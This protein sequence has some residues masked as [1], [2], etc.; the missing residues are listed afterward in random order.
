MRW[1]PQILLSEDV[2]I[3]FPEGQRTGFFF[4]TLGV[5]G[6]VF[7][8]ANDKKERQLVSELPNRQ[9]MVFTKKITSLSK[10]ETWGPRVDLSSKILLNNKKSFRS[11]DFFHRQKSIQRPVVEKPIAPKPLQGGKACDTLVQVLGGEKVFL[12]LHSVLTILPPPGLKDSAINHELQN[13]D[14]HNLRGLT[15]EKWRAFL[16]HHYALML[17]LGLQDYP[18]AGCRVPHPQQNERFDSRYRLD[19]QPFKVS[20]KTLGFSLFLL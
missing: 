14:C 19:Q 1:I 15:H 11:F 13:A 5:I 8:S 10:N 17:V 9:V 6:E 4:R 16:L 12:K 3:F 18:H 20:K 2:V 7:W